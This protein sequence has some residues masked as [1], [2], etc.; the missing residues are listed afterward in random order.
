MEAASQA[1][2]R[3]GEPFFGL[4]PKVQRRLSQE[5]A[6]DVCGYVGRSG[7]FGGDERQPEVEVPGLVRQAA[8][9]VAACRGLPGRGVQAVEQPARR[10]WT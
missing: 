6:G 7:L 2:G 4:W 8:Q 10:A 5:A 1:G 3:R 9:Q